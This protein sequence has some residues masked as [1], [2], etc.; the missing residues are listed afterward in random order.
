M[1]RDTF[2]VEPVP[3]FRPDLIVWTLRRQPDN[4]VDRWDGT[5]YRRVLP[6]HAGRVADAET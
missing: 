2:L 5:T 6:L 1:N 3:P 4:A